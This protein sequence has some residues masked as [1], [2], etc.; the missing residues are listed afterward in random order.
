MRVLD[1]YIGKDFLAIFGLSLSI[2]TFIMSIGLL[3]R[4]VDLL[5]R[6]LPL[7]V[8]GMFFFYSIPKLLMFTMPISTLLA[9][10]LLFSRL[11]TDSEVVALKACGMSNWQ[12]AAPVVSWAV[13]FSVICF[14]FA[15]YISPNGAH[16]NK[17]IKRMGSVNPIDLLEEGAFIHDIPGIQISVDRKHGNKVEGVL[18]YELEGS[19]IKHC[20]RAQ[21]GE[22]NFNEETQQLMIDLYNVRIETPDSEDSLDL[23]GERYITAQHYPLK[24]DV[25]ELMKK[26]TLRRKMKNMTLS[27]LV[28]LRNM[29]EERLQGLGSVLAAERMKIDMEIS[30]RFATALSCLTFAL[31][32]IPLGT[33]HHRKESSASIGLSLVVILVFYGF[34]IVADALKDNPAARSD[35]IIWA[36]VLAGQIY[37]L[38][39]LLKRSA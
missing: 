35:L 1:R 19:K 8:I 15:G 3:I 33:Q 10:L 27:H 21:N 9:T 17:R 14:F 2:L 23:A 13:V 39:K 30:K 31:I 7:S 36:P 11:S 20:V 29:L 22:L 18:A 28:A 6:G 34:Q 26:N 32:G 37:G 4:S 16:A 12:V 25:K 24:L 5:A 38:A